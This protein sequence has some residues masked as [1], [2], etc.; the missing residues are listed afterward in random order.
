MPETKHAQWKL[1]AAFAAVYIVWGSTYLAIRYAIETIPPF[2]MAGSRFLL[3]G[4]VLLIWS[5][6]RGA[7]RPKWIHWRTALI[8]GAFMLLVGNG[9]VTW[10]EQRIVSGVAALLIASEPLWLVLLAWAWPGGIA[11]S[12]VDLAAIGLGFGGVA[13]LFAPAWSVGNAGGFHLFSAALIL[14][15]AISWAAGSLYGTT[16]PMS[17]FSGLANAMTMLCGGA[18]LFITGVMTGEISRFRP[19]T[20]S[21]ASLSAFFYLAIFGSLIGF[22]SYMYLLAHTTPAKASTYAFVNPVVAVLLGWALAGEPLTR[23][24]VLAMCT[25]VA[26]VVLITMGQSRKRKQVRVNDPLEGRKP[27]AQC[28]GD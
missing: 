16:A 26:A 3:S 24:S 28:A 1:L 21:I 12:K 4:S 22:T 14:V 27:V 7:E 13:L 17:R 6:W 15:S 11:P 5:I 23:S 2:L 20:I 9:A 18:L 19:D 10:A 25:I 8:M